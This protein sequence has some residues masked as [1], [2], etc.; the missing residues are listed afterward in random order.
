[1]RFSLQSI[2][3]SISKLAHSNG[4][5]EEKLCLHLTVDCFQDDHIKIDNT[6]IIC[7]EDY[8][9]QNNLK[10]DYDSRVTCSITLAPQSL[11]NHIEP[12]LS[13]DYAILLD[14]HLSICIFLKDELFCQF[15]H[16]MGSYRVL[17]DL[18]ISFC[19]YPGLNNFTCEI[20]RDG[21]VGSWTTV[22]H[23]AGNRLSIE[24]FEFNCRIYADQVKID[25]I[26]Q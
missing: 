23:H 13:T 5:C 3:S 2:D 14:G 6:L 8:Y 4:L 15:S 7:S 18:F 24:S 21:E 10:R 17:N 26:D 11:N 25:N 1:M 19:S 16:Q 12:S 20:S 9:K 22:S